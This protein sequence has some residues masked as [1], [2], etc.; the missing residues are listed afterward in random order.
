MKADDNLAG[1]SILSVAR[2]VE[3]YFL[4]I[5]ATLA[6]TINTLHATLEIMSVQVLDWITV[7]DIIQ[8]GKEPEIEV[9]R[10]DVSKSSETGFCR[11]K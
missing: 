9:K 10:I 8:L 4:Y 5:N 1:Y 11:G 6:T 2:T 3:R 7:L